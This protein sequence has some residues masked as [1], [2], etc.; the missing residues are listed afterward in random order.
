MVMDLLAMNLPGDLLRVKGI[1]WV[2]AMARSEPWAVHAAGPL[3]HPAR[4]ITGPSLSKLSPNATQIVVITRTDQSA[5]DQRSF[6]C[7]P[8]AEPRIGYPRLIQ[9]VAR[10]P[11]TF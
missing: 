3:Q 11:F 9:N 7:L 10:A 8:E 6:R 4:P 2:Q 5:A 1:A